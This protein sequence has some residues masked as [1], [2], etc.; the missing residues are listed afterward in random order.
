M[1]EQSL[2]ESI[3][4]IKNEIIDDDNNNFENQDDHQ[5]NIEHQINYEEFT[6]NKEE[7]YGDD[8]TFE[9][10][11]DN[12]IFFPIATKLVDPLYNLSLTP[13]NVTVLSTIFTF[14]SI[15]FLHQNERLYA[16]L[17]YFSGYLLDCVDGKMARKYNMSSRYGMALDLVSDNISNLTLVAYLIN[18]FG[19]TNKFV[20][21]IIFMSY[22][23]SVSYGM[24][25][26]IASQKATGSDNFL[27]K[28]ESELKTEK[29]YIFTLFLYITKISY[30]S[31][32]SFFKEYDEE[33]IFKWL[34][35][36][37][38]F[39]PGNYCLLVSIILLYIE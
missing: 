19:L 20:L 21:V 38:H 13:N 39:G 18:R 3:E 22:M 9:S 14:L 2:S 16:A 34:S 28:R 26:A 33:K 8:E 7:K 30:R 35:I 32:R 4:S 24:N 25:E 11:A 27:M 10:W 37:K 6:S 15:Y 36:L 29:D 12:N 31:Y 5:I 1:S 17:A 23:I